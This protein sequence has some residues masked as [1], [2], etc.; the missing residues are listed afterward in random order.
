M[1]ENLIPISDNQQQQIDFHGLLAVVDIQETTSNQ[2]IHENSADSNILTPRSNSQVN[3]S[4]T[5]S[6][7]ILGSPTI[8][9]YPIG[10]LVEESMPNPTV[11]FPMISDCRN[12]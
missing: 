1:A 10:F 11:V 7:R 4:D 6:H 3:Q 9:R 12:Q 5:E 2:A 8:R